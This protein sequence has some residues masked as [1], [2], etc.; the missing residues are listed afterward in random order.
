MKL[1]ETCNQ[2]AKW[3]KTWKTLPVLHWVQAAALYRAGEYRLAEKFYRKGLKRH[4]EHIASFCARLDLAYCLYKQGKIAESEQ[5]LKYVTINLPQMREAHLRLARLQL[6]KGHALDAAWTI[7]R[8]LRVLTPDEEL[9]GTFLNAVIENEGP[10]Y[11]M[12]EAREFTQRLSAKQINSPKIRAPLAYLE[13][14]Q[15]GCSDAQIE[16]EAICE[17]ENSPPESMILLSQVLLESG[18][19]L[20]A[21]RLLRRALVTLPEHPRVLN[22]LARS[23]LMSGALYN[24]EYAKQLATQAC[25]LTEWSSPRDMHMLAEAF[26]HVGDKVSALIIAS[27]AKEEG[28]RLLGSYRDVKSLDQLIDSLST[29]TLA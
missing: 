20:Q 5:E 12:D 1:R 24:S 2:L 3:W 6:W 4:P 22:L 17:S 27:K 16:L 19:V 21:R 25:Q 13:I 28:T 10:W 11:L 23:Y 26:Y 9:I 29:G 14:S 15:N 7:R 8:A 18:K